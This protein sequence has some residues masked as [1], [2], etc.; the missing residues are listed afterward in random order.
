MEIFRLADTVRTMPGI[1]PAIVSNRYF[2]DRRRALLAGSDLAKQYVALLGCT[3]VWTPVDRYG[4]VC[5][6]RDHPTDPS[7]EIRIDK[8]GV[9]DVAELDS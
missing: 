8:G 5:L 7:V 9:E 4:I 2:R 3:L 1:P 6:W